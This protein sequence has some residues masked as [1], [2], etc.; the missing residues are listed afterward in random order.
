MVV[1]PRG[2]PHER[3]EGLRK[4]VEHCTVHNSITQAPEIR[5]TTEIPA[6]TPG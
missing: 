6:V 2:F 1:L 4:V 3:L 5:I